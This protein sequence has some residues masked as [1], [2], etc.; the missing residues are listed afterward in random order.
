MRSIKRGST[1]PRCPDHHWCMSI[2]LP[3]T[4]FIAAGSTRDSRLLMPRHA[5]APLARCPDRPLGASTRQRNATG[6]I[7][8]R[9]A[10]ITCA[11]GARQFGRQLRTHHLAA[12][13]HVRQARLVGAAAGAAATSERIFL[14]RPKSL[15][16]QPLDHI[17]PILFPTL[18]LLKQ[19]LT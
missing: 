3:V 16:D 5:Y 4:Y 18:S 17:A 7:V 6:L 13:P 11:R 1:K 15:A 10:Q 14:R 12:A 8:H 2:D 19:T 9:S